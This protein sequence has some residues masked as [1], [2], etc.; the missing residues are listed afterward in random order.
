MVD[1]D[2]KNVWRNILIIIPFLILIYFYETNLL[3]YTFSKSV[4]DYRC[5]VDFALKMA[6]SGKINTPHFLYQLLVI[7][8]TN[9]FFLPSSPPTLET[10]LKGAY[11]VSIVIAISLFLMLLVILRLS[12][13]RKEVG[14]SLLVACISLFFMMGSA[15]N[16]FTPLDRHAYLGYLPLNIYHNPTIT[17]L[18]LC[19]IPLFLISLR[20]FKPSKSG[21]LW[22][23]L[24]SVLFSILCALSKP[25]FTVIILPALGV[26]VIYKLW[27]NEYV[28]WTLLLLGILLPSAVVLG[29][30]YLVLW[31][32]G[33]ELVDQAIYEAGLVTPTRMALVPF[34]QLIRWKVPLFLLLPKLLFSILFPLTVYVAF[35]K[36]SH[37]DLVFNLGWLIFGFGCLSTYFL[38]EINHKGAILFA[39]NFTWSGLIGVFMLFLSTTIFWLKEISGKFSIAELGSWRFGIPILAL[40]LHWVFG[41]I[42]YLDQF[43]LDIGKMF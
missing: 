28:D 14:Y 39:G 36:K 25:S 11:L 21:K 42:W 13:K 34:G 2:K 30:Q 31:G 23:V 6:E 33:W 3:S 26:V 15:I 41:I 17:L 18:K 37:K 27:K 5:H 22:S 12:I 1:F 38:V 24:G 32:S 16:V 8:A 20:I 9:L 4:S 7:E 40:A 19:S 10:Y 29:W 43:R 35:W